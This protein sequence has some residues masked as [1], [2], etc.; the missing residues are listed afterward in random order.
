MA[1][2]HSVFDE[3]LERARG[4]TTESANKDRVA[5][6]AMKWAIARLH[7]AV[8]GDRQEL[9]VSGGLKLESPLAQAPEWLKALL[10][11]GAPVEVGGTSVPPLLA[12]VVGK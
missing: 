12:A 10:P 4:V 9:H 1:Q 8:Y 6:D 7:P 2:A 11:G 3:F 5:L